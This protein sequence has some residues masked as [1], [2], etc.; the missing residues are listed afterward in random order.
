[1]KYLPHQTRKPVTAGASHGV[2]T[3]IGWN[4][5]VVQPSNVTISTNTRQTLEI[6][7][8]ISN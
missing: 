2:L 8:S 3:A 7:Q 6:A 4:L 1:M 5:V